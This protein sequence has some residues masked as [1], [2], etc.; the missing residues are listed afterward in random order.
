MIEMRIAG[1][2]KWSFADEESGFHDIRLPIGP[3]T[4]AGNVLTVDAGQ[5]DSLSVTNPSALVR[6]RG[7]WYLFYAGSNDLTG[8][9]L[10]KVGVAISTDKGVTWVKGA[11][12]PII[13]APVNYTAQF[14]SVVYDEDEDKYKMWTNTYEY[15][16]GANK[17]VYYQECDGADDPTDGANWGSPTICTGLTN[18]FFGFNVNKIAAGQ[19]YYGNFRDTNNQVVAAYSSNGIAWTIIG[20][21]VLK[22]AG[23]TWDDFVTAYA[24][25]FW[26]MGVWYIVYSG[27][28]GSRYRIGMSTSAD[29]LT[30]AKHWYNGGLIIPT[31]SPV[32]SRW[33]TIVRWDK[34][35]QM[36]VGYYNGTIWSI[37]KYTK[38]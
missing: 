35:Y 12:N 36:Y 24:S 16:G 14:V 6:S 22:G 21:I 2:R 9:G 15:V 8:S 7:L 18:F 23:G 11:N 30:Y 27:H 1:H 25:L 4:D 37:R 5:W 32:S 31:S 19:F 26:N 13:T 28:D 29:G 33:P 10:Y 17:N 38:P 20:T 3:W 34:D